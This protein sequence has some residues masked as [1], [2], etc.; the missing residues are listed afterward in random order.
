M[1]L[2]CVGHFSPKTKTNYQKNTQYIKYVSSNEY[3][4]LY[5]RLLDNG[6]T[7]QHNSF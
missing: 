3:L 1:S 7:S 6:M 2:Y 4:R 5:F